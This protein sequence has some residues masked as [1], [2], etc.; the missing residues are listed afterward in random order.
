MRNT[1]DALRGWRDVVRYALIAIFAC[2]I[3]AGASPQA[4]QLSTHYSLVAR[5]GLDEAL[6]AEAGDDHRARSVHP[7]GTRQIIRHP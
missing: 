6:S 5:E 1:S 7:R 3:A 2:A 4:R